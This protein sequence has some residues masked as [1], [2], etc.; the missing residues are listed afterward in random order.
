M[1]IVS[2]ITVVYNGEPYIELTIQSVINQTFED[3]EY[4]VI[5]GSSKD[6]T[7]QIIS[8][9]ED[10]ITKVISEPDQGVYDAMNKGLEIATGK[11]LLFLN[12]GDQLFSPATLTNIFSSDTIADVYYGETVIIDEKNESLGTRTELTSR[13]LPKS[14]VKNDFLKGQVVSHQSFIPKKVLV[15]PY[16]LKYKC[17]A[18]IA[19]MLAIMTTAQVVVNVQ[20]PISK[21]L[22]GGISDR[23]L[24]T[25]WKERFAIMLN[26]FNPVTVLWAHV[27]F[28]FRLLNYGRY[29]K[30]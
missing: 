9:Y 27:Q 8:S 23:H 15:K 28:A 13:K 5:D 1:P 21:Y 17:S 26:H 19:W 16:N 7:F 2:I 10:K 3:F 12:A 25:C 14:L 29:K 18:D 22:Q 4:I 11:Y 6:K 30:K 24:I 20:S